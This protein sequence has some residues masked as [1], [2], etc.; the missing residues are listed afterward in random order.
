MDTQSQELFDRIISMDQELLTAD[1]KGFLMARREYFN[2]EQKKRY[3]SMI[4]EHEANMGKPAKGDEEVP[5]TKMTKKELLAKAKELEVEV[6]DSM[7][8]E[9]IIEAIEAK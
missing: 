6:E 7:T 5:L 2:D 4:E 9:E 3:A 8:K 1:Q